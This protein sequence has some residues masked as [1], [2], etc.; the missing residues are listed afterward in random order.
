[1]KALKILLGIVV[2]GVIALLGVGL[3]TPEFEYE[4]EV[5]IDKPVATVWAVF[6]DESRMKDWL[7]GLVKVENLAGKPLEVGSRWRLEFEVDGEEV[8]VDETVTAVEPNRR[9]AFDATTDVF[10]GPTEITFTELDGR[11]KVSARSRVVGGNVFLRAF[12]RMAK[13]MMV[14]Q[15]QKSYDALK[16]VCE[17]TP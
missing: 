9:Y 7:F 16:R 11:T 2:L 4:N 5:V 14:E 12:L 6:T 17:A 15:S 13:S 3:A 1:M 10:T 8:I